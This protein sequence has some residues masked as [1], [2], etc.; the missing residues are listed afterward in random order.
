MA[1]KLAVEVIG[2]AKPAFEFVIVGAAKVVN[3]HL[4]NL[5][6]RDGGRTRTA[7]GREI[8]SLYG[9]RIHAGLESVRPVVNYQCKQLVV[10]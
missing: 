8:L 9:S 1:L 7:N 10:E 2:A 4:F 5:G 3:D 6:A